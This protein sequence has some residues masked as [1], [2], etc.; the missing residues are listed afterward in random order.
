MV[1]LYGSTTHRFKDVIQLN[2]VL[3]VS[4][5]IKP[6]PGNTLEYYLIVSS[7]R[8]QWPQTVLKVKTSHPIK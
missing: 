8:F 4:S 7:F 5:I 2:T 3:W 6:L 1:S